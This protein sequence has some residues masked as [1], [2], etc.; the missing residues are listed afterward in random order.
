[1]KHMERRFVVDGLFTVLLGFSDFID[2]SIDVD[3]TD[4]LYDKR[5][6][7]DKI[8]LILKNGQRFIVEIK[9]E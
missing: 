4:V 3:E 1:M 9:E 5:G 7:C 2:T 8:R 6:H